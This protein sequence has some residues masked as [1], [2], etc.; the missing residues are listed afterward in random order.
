M[1]EEL[2]EDE[3]EKLVEH[4]KT[5]G[6][7][8]KLDTLGEFKAWMHD[9]MKVGAESKAE[10]QAEIAKSLLSST[11]HFPKL[12]HFSG[13]SGKDVHYEIWRNEVKCIIKEG[14]SS[15][16]VAQ[17]IRSS[18]KGNA[19]R[20][21][22]LLGPSATTE[23]VL[24]KMDSVFGIVDEHEIK[25]SKFYAAFQADDEDVAIWS[26]RL[27]DLLVQALGSKYHSNDPNEMLRSRFWNGLRPSLKDATGHLY[28][29]IQNFDELRIEVRRIDEDRKRQKS[30]DRGKKSLQT[31]NTAIADPDPS[32]ELRDLK[33][34]VQQL[35]SEVKQFKESMNNSNFYP[36]DDTYNN[37]RGR[38]RYRG[39]RGGGS[40][41]R[42]PRRGGHY[43]H[44]TA[45]E[46]YDTC[47][48]CFECGQKGHLAIGCRN[49]DYGNPLN[50]KGPARRG[51]R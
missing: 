11:H 25:M 9:V 17:A 42:G 45:H 26:C 50:G 24:Y 44:Q 31:A 16:T 1:S 36:H 37:D 30:D 43:G 40:R 35:S 47:A 20:V 4:L 14:H 51:M 48:E 12:V 41:A 22:S 3:V 29:S 13:E 23:E 28:R 38:S 33:G 21:R 19:L 18:L 2:T 46:E 8:P 27:E 32:K 39:N 15:Q 7:K 34:I 49:K 5:I 10:I 6:V